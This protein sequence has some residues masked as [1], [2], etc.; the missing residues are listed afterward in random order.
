[1]LLAYSH[2]IVSSRAIEWMCRDRVM[3]IAL[4]GD[5]QPRF[6]TIAA[7]IRTLG[8]EIARIVAQMLLIRH[9]MVQRAASKRTMSA[10]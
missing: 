6:T 7:F 3:F 5:S 10:I 1:M 4:S 2:G 9:P 8:D